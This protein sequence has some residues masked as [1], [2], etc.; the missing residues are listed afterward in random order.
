MS[1]KQRFVLQPGQKCCA[2]FRTIKGLTPMCGRIRDGGR[3]RFVCCKACGAFNVFDMK[4]GTLRAFVSSQDKADLMASPNLAMWK[5]RH[6]AI[7]SKFW[8]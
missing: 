5:A 3:K 1:D 7:V 8:G 2:C 4:A 6:D